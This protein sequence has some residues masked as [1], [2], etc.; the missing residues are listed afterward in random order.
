[1]LNFYRQ[2]YL[3]FSY[4]KIEEIKMILYFYKKIMARLI[5]WGNRP[6]VEIPWYEWIYE[7]N[8]LWQIRSYWRNCQKENEIAKEPQRLLQ[9][10]R[11]HLKVYWDKAVV[12]LF[13][14]LKHK[15]F[16]VA[17]LVAWLFMGLDVKNK[18]L[19]VIH[20]DWNNMNCDKRNLYIATVSERQLNYF[21]HLAFNKLQWENLIH[22]ETISHQ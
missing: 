12:T 3:L 13:D 1:M 6:R 4:E 21:K 17:R 10:R 11:K 2:Y 7:I 8:D 18:K 14:W 19:Q 16:Y 9:P 20:K 5:Y 15:H 22:I